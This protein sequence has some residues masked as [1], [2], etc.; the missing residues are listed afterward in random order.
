MMT[1]S[2]ASQIRA[3]LH[4]RIANLAGDRSRLNQRQLLETV[5]AIRSIAH[6][7]GF[8]TVS[9]LASRLE[10]ALAQDIAGPTL[11]C[12]LDAMDDAIRLEPVR[13]ASVQQAL[14]A[15]IALRMGA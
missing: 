11:L 3:D 6:H 2:R 12:Y 1:E 14:L 7:A 10:S 13:A 9:S 5:D 4:S 15:S 8:V